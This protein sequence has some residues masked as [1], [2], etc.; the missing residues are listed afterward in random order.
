MIGKYYIEVGN[1]RISFKVVVKRS[2]TII[3]GYSGSGKSTF[4]NMLENALN[5]TITGV[6]LRTDY[7]KEKIEVIRNEKQMNYA[8]NSKEENKIFVIDENLNLLK[9][10]YFVEFLKTSGSYLIYITRKNNTGLLQYAVDE[11]YRFESKTSD[12]YTT[13]NM[14]PKYNNIMRNIKP[15]IIVTEDSNSGH[16]IVEHIVNVPVI[17]SE[18]KDNVANIINNLKTDGHHTIYVLADCA[19]FG[20]CIEKVI[21]LGAYVCKNESFEYMILRTYIFNRYIN[22]ELEETYL[23]AESSI[24][25][26]WE[27]YYTSLLQELCK[28]IPNCTY[29]KESWNRLNNVFKSDKFLME[30]SEQLDELDS[31]VKE[32]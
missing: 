28:R 15:D 21:R 1:K 7:D 24:H 31:S 23:F 4:I 20:N 5:N 14:F 27:Q 11:I 29:R 6:F 2:V 26:T 18:G 12:N 9:Y 8:I 16:D 30:I 3:R 10:E 19:A 25:Y 22:N 32:I 17:T 13:V